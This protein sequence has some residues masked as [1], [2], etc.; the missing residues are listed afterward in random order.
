MNDDDG[1][2]DDTVSMPPARA[3]RASAQ[4]GMLPRADGEPAADPSAVAHGSRAPGESVASAEAHTLPFHGAKAPSPGASSSHNG[5]RAD[6]RALLPADPDHYVLGDEIARGGMGRI[7]AARDRRLGRA[8]AIKEL[9]DGSELM[10]ARF[11]REARITARLQHPAT[12]RILEAGVWPDGRLF[13]VMDLV[14]GQALDK[15]IA[16]RSTADARFDLLANVIAAVDT[17]A[18]AHNLHVIH[19]DLK[20]ANI[21]CGDFGETVVIDWGLAKD[22]GDPSGPD[23]SIGPVRRVGSTDTLDGAVIGTPAYMPPEQADGQPVDARADVYALGAILYHVLAGVA[24]YTG[25]SGEA[26]LVDVLAGPPMSLATRAPG[27]PPDLITIVHKA[28]ARAPADRYSSA[29][30]LAVELKRFQTGQLVGSHRYTPGQLVARWIRRHRAAVAV[31]AAAAI[32]LASGATFSVRRVLREEQRAEAQRALAV[33]RGADAEELMSFMLGDLRDKL[34]PLGKLELLDVVATKA[35]AY[36]AQRAEGADDV[37]RSQRARA[38]QNL[39]NVLQSE[40]KLPTAL[41][42]FR[43]AA[44]LWMQLAADPHNLAA[45]FGLAA[46]RSEIASV[47]RSQ[48]DA[49]AARVEYEHALASLERVVAQDPG[50]PERQLQ[51]VMTHRELGDLLV[52]LGDGPA[53]IAQFRAAIAIAGSAAAAAPDDVRWQRALSVN[54]SQ[55]GG[56]LLMQGDTKAALVEH[57]ADVAI[58]ER[59]AAASPKDALLQSDLAGGHSRIGDVLHRTGDARGALVEYRFA[60]AIAARLADADPANADWQQDCAVSH[61]RVGNILLETGDAPGALAAYRAAMA[62]KQRLVER[63]P[64]NLDFRRNLATGHNKVGNVMETKGDVAGALAEYRAGLALLEALTAHD[65]ANA[66]W[67]RDLAVSHYLVADMLLA[68][69]DPAGALVEHRASLAIVEKLAALDPKNAQWQGDVIDSHTQV[70]KVL[71][72]LHQPAD[73]LAAYRA[74]LTIAQTLAAAEPTNPAWRDQV[75]TLTST[76]AT[77]CAAHR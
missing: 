44:A 9:L 41:A 50:K 60:L 59:L 24:P 33:A 45:A 34:K 73:A 4:G 23:V 47:L 21:L 30:E 63:D 32:V 67:Q 35:V 17:I 28:M 12:I 5:G 20:P 15:A 13:Y 19:R 40:A 48:G 11:E 57:R 62:I 64:S 54:H 76:V 66:G 71:R 75:K 69:H 68:H 7:L 16:A 36:Y 14:A 61:D 39:G 77:C 70:G 8:V 65:P 52:E 29:K 43:E 37:Q 74:A 58:S 10:R 51:L 72:A 53:A 25:R 49:A 42:T 27:T 22:L 1:A 26:V 46:S 55:L 18:Y 6:Y 38:L 3:P 56:A 2:H 31:A